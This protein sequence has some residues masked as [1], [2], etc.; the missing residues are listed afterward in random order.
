MCAGRSAIYRRDEEELLDK[1]SKAIELE[2]YEEAAVFRDKL[3]E[4]RKAKM[5]IILYSELT[6]SRN[7]SGA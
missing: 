6:L 1:L 3:K 7:I 4:L 2:N 5:S